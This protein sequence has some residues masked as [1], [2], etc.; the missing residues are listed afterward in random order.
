MVAR[1]G[2]GLYVVSDK[3]RDDQ[4]EIFA[5]DGPLSPL[6]ARYDFETSTVLLNDALVKTDSFTAE[7]VRLEIAPRVRLH[8]YQWRFGKAGKFELPDRAALA[9]LGEAM[10][11]NKQGDQ[12]ESEIPVGYTY[13]GQFIAHDLTFASNDTSKPKDIRTP[14]LD[15]DSVYDAPTI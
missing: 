15:L 6:F 11:A 7:D 3:S 1:H 9:A 4:V 10:T 2:F 5:D 13:L 8:E 12:R 14:T